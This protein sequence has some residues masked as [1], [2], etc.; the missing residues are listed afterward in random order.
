MEQAENGLFLNS[1]S[2]KSLI[3][4]IDLIVNADPKQ[5]EFLEGGTYDLRVDA[6]E[7]MIQGAPALIGVNKRITPKTQPLE[8]RPLAKGENMG[9]ALYPGKT[10]LIKTLEIIDCPK[11]LRAW[12]TH[13]TTIFRDGAEFVHPTNSANPGEPTKSLCI[14]AGMIQPGYQGTLTFKLRV[15]GPELIELEQ[16]ARVAGIC[17]SRLEAPE[18]DSYD[19]QGKWQGGKVSSQGQEMEAH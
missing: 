10:Y 14:A 18:P 13:K 9:W 5:V 17:F 15:D 3:Q 12:V 2:V 16:H 7:R 4:E 1:T 19:K 8:P 11:S 6:V